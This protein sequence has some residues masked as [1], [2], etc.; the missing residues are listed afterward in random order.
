VIF[1]GYDT[2]VTAYRLGDGPDAVFERAW[3]NNDA[4]LYMS[5]PVLVGERLIGFSQ[6]KKG[7]LFALD[8]E[9]GETLWTG[10]GRQG[11]NAS[12]LVAGEIV[13]AVSTT[14]EM[15]VVKVTGD[16]YEELARHRLSDFPIWAH[17]APCADGLLVKDFENLMLYRWAK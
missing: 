9:T 15:I 17:A 14:G 6:Y 10:P 11:D 5:S 3:S 4:A 12:L 16:K 8:A 13:V 1:S 2:P 7:Q